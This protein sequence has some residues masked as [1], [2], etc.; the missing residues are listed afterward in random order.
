M[1][2]EQLLTRQE[3]LQSLR[4]KQLE[5]AQEARELGANYTGIIMEHACLAL[6]FAIEDSA[7]KAP[8]K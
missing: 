5:L 3:R 6:K 8:P 4:A 1:P 2:K 7:D